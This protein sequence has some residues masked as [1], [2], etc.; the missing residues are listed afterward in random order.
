MITINT[1]AD[2]TALTIYVS[3]RVDSI[4]APELDKRISEALPGCER[5]ILDFAGLEYISSAGLRILM[6]LAK[7]MNRLGGMKFRNVA[8]SVS[9]IFELTGLLAVFDVE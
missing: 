9:E 1:R 7:T 8:E 5:L 4:T 6:S 3:G 2:G